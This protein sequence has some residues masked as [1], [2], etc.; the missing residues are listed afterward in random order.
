[1]PRFS[2]NLS[3]LYPEHDFLDRF[4]AA[5]ADGFKAVEF[6]FPCAFD[7]RELAEKAQDQG[8]DLV[9]FNL[10]AGDWVLGERG[11]A[12]HPRRIGE[13]GFPVLFGQLDSLGYRGR[14]GCECRPLARSSWIG[15]WR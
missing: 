15:P 9:L 2:A 10:P 3:L 14:L 5:R 13:I 11:I 1:M 12:C 7:Q 4:S 6:Q 8:L